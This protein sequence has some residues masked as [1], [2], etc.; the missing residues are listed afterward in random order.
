MAETGHPGRSLAKPELA[1][2]LRADLAEKRIKR[3]EVAHWTERSVKTIERWTSED[4]SNASY[5][6]SRSEAI[7]VAFLTGYPVSRYTGDDRDD[8][9]F[10][11]SGTV[12]TLSERLRAVEERAGGRHDVRESRGV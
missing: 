5:R 12:R 7:V 10:P 9:L 8:I 6:P 3:K 4:P 2:R 11:L 1:A